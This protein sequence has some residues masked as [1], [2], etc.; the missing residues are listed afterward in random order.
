M[1][2]LN[3]YL[4]TFFKLSPRQQALT[5][6]IAQSELYDFSAILSGIDFDE[7][8]HEAQKRADF[9]DKSFNCDNLLHNVYTAVSMARGF[10]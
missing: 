4:C 9:F 2:A 1:G 3:G 7:Q 6:V 5:V 8:C 10:K